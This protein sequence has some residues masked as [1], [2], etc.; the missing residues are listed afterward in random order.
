[1]SDDRYDSSE[2]IRKKRKEAIK[3]RRREQY[4]KAKEKFKNSEY[5]KMMKEK[6]KELRREAYRKAK[7]RQRDLQE[8]HSETSA[9]EDLMWQ[10]L[11]LVKMES[12]SEKDEKLWKK[13][14]PAS[15]IARPKLRLIKNNENEK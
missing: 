14:K 2:E 3:Q 11:T 5:A 13:I 4:L 6:Q 10:K 15:E 8:K 9:P 1:M 12:R 7:Q